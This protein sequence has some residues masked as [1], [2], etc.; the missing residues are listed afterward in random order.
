MRYQCSSVR[1]KGSISITYI[2]PGH[3]YTL[4]LVQ[5]VWDSFLDFLCIDYIPFSA[6]IIEILFIFRLLLLS[7]L[8]LIILVK[9][10]SVGYA[11]NP[12][13]NMS[14]SFPPASEEVHQKHSLCYFSEGQ[15]ATCPSIC[16]G[17]PLEPLSDWTQQ[18]ARVV[19]WPHVA[20]GRLASHADI[21]VLIINQSIYELPIC[22]GRLML[23]SR[24]T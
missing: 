4:K 5:I 20:A 1:K 19:L 7:I 17:K 12:D 13:M 16:K 21:L 15:L 2:K 6:Y 22:S 8:S 24:P 11:L 10:G 3:K 23:R 18:L 14:A 9:W